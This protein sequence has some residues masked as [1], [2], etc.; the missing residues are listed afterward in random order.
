MGKTRHTYTTLIV[1]PD[2]NGPFERLGRR[3]DIGINM[4]FKVKECVLRISI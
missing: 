1:N 2:R 4:D 3:Y